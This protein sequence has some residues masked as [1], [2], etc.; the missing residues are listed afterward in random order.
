MIISTDQ[1]LD[2]DRFSGSRSCLCIF[3]SWLLGLLPVFLR[4][5]CRVSSFWT[6]N[7]SSTF[8][9][10]CLK[11]GDQFL[12]FGKHCLES[13]Q[14]SLQLFNRDLAPTLW[15]RG[16]LGCDPAA[17]L[18]HV[19]IQLVPALHQ[20]CHPCNPLLEALMHHSPPLSEGAHLLVGLVVTCHLLRGGGSIL[21]NLQFGLGVVLEVLAVSKDL[22]RLHQGHWLLQAFLFP[23]LGVL[24][25][26]L[27]HLDPSL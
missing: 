27:K 26:G 1:E 15:S 4:S 2:E 25:P 3:N 16:V 11:I 6:C 21:K 17:Q 8:W 22:A 7:R 23:R 20:G 10:I 14:L 18:S 19:A 13:V 9:S 5:R 12:F 24:K